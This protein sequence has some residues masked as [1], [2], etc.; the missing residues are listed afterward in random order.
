MGRTS[1]A[2]KRL[3]DAAHELIWNHGYGNASIDK[4]CQRAR[5]KKGTFY[6]FFDSKSDLAV[7]AIQA[8]W[9]GQKKEMEG[10]VIA[11][12]PPLERIWKFLDFTA[13]VQIKAYENDGQV[14]GWPLFTIGT[15]M[16]K[17]DRRLQSLL[18]DILGYLKFYFEEA[19]R[20]A[21]AAGEVEGID[22][23]QKGRLLWAYYEGTLTRARVEN[24]PDLIR[25]LSAD[26]RELIYASRPVLP[27]MRS[28]GMVLERESNRRETFAEF[29]LMGEHAEEMVV[30]TDAQWRIE[31]VNQAFVQT[32]GYT[33]GELRGKKP[34]HLLQ[35]AD[36]D[37]QA[38]QSLREAIHSS[39]PCECRIINYRKNGKP[40]EVL[41]S[42][43][44]VYCSGRLGGYLAVEKE[45]AAPTSF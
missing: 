44:P 16:R 13:Q 42:L 41:I 33:L 34:G 40:Y 11:E 28:N 9:E 32:C 15:E 22:A 21:Q 12:E 38:V 45:L 8:W 1:D 30:L 25:N 7:A 10:F 14:L 20:E 27:S 26:A 29:A 24:N 17:T 36:S 43:G 35:G 5:A 18:Q 3:T 23:V 2:R 19:I 4:I 37:P 31:W 39:R 6:H